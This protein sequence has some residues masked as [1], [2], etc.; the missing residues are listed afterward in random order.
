VRPLFTATERFDPSDGNKWL[1]YAEFAEIP[2]LTE[3]VS[4]DG[5][6]C[7][8][9]IGPF[10]NEDWAHA[11]AE[12]LHRGISTINWFK[13]LDY[14][15]AKIG[16]RERRNVLGVYQ[17]ADSHVNE[18]PARGFVFLGYDLIGEESGI[19]ALTNCGGFPESF[20]NGELNQYGLLADFGR[21]S[22]VRRTLR[23]R[24]P[25]EHHAQCDLFA[26]WRLVEI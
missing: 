5:L 18:A 12:F 2:D 25:E 24:N 22:E 17:N 13:D 3:L 26:I 14:L 15:L 6:L 23:E 4:L 16:D 21:A 10:D 7:P 8:S 20:S 9:L 19:S 1:E 11:D